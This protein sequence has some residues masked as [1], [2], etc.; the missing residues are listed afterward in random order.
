MKKLALAL[1]CSAIVSIPATA[2]AQDSAR[3]A[4]PI[5]APV[6]VPA[7]M[8]AATPAF[9]ASPIRAGTPIALKM[10]EEVTTRNKVAKIGQRFQL[11]VLQPVL[12]NGAEVIP[13]GT[14]ARGELT[15]VRNKGMWGK[16]GKLEAKLLFARTNGR[17]VRLSGSFDD[18]GTTGTAGVI[19]AI[20]MA[21]IVSFFV[22][23]TSATLSMGMPVNGFIDEDVDM[24]APVAAPVAPSA[25]EPTVPAAG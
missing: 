23:G 15:S 8:P 11:E 20:V 5:A 4:A 2:Q 9:S 14:P 13:A 3:A 25:V 16:S 21:P 19:G 12:V 24:N 10:S 18:K 1:L 6:A 22:T 17:Q 7:A